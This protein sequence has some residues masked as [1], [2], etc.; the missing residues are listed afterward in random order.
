MHFCAKA[1]VDIFNPSCPLGKK[2]IIQVPW[3]YTSPGDVKTNLPVLHD[4]DISEHR[5]LSP[6]SS[7]ALNILEHVKSSYSLES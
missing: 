4:S 7:P 6:S 1:K 2:I 3:K 5:A